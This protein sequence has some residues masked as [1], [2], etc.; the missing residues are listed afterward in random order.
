[1]NRD[2]A[3]QD[4]VQEQRRRER[5]GLLPRA[6]FERVSEWRRA[7]SK[8][9]AEWLRAFF[10]GISGFMSPSFYRIKIEALNLSGQN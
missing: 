7:F 8:K 6:F 9:V 4:R 2:E 1:M 5:P 10:K 3:W